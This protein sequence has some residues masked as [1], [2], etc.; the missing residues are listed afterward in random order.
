MSPE[1]IPA[2]LAHTFEEYTTK[3]GLVEDSRATWVHVDIMDGQFV[4]NIT[5]MPHEIMSIG[6]RLKL[7]AHLMTHAPERYFSDLTV[8][9]CARVLL[10]REA[11]TDLESCAKAVKQAQDYFTEVGLV[12]NPGTAMEPYANLGLSS[13]QV[14][15]AE[16]GRSGQSLLDSTYDRLR[17]L[18]A[19]KLPGVTLAVD[20]GVSEDTIA[21]LREAGA[22]RFVIATHLFVNNAVSQNFTYFSQLVTGGAA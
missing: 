3:L 8:A 1:I 15:G 11:Y 6:T 18:A 19:Q 14:M 5:V 17:E 13:I 7:E 4:P 12:L 10:H 9:G 20:C 22:Q 21:G 2:I 16:P